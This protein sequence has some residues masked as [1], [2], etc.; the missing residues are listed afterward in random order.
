VKTLRRY[1]DRC[2]PTVL[3]RPL[4]KSKKHAPRTGSAPRRAG[5]S[6]PTRTRALAAACMGHGR[7]HI[8][9]DA[10]HDERC[11]AMP[12]VRR[13][14]RRLA[15]SRVRPE[16]VET[17]SAHA[18][19]AGRRR[20]GAWR[21]ARGAAPCARTPVS[22]ACLELEPELSARRLR[23]NRRPARQ[24]AGTLTPLCSARRLA[25]ALLSWGRPWR[26]RTSITGAPHLG[27]GHFCVRH[28]ARCPSPSRLV[29]GSGSL[30]NADG[31]GARVIGCLPR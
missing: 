15:G 4:A 23:T 2:D 27:S 12:Q 22:P 28:V 21:V 19:R 10:H 31:S 11:L 9:H 16:T 14:W 3:C 6:A 24:H 18:T 25:R 17:V 29:S 30:L 7:V 26:E 13:T 5:S 1:T 20:R 8:V